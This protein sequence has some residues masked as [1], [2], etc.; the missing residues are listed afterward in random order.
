MSKRAMRATWRISSASRR[1]GPAVISRVSA[2]SSCRVRDRAERLLQVAD[3]RR[4]EQA[5][6]ADD[7]VRDVLVA[8]PRHDR[9]AMLVLAVQHGDV[10]PALRRAVLVADGVDDRDRLVLRAGAGH[11]LHGRAAASVATSRL[12]GSKRVWL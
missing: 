2:T 12:S 8:Q 1:H 5:Q 10:R 11:H 9:V 7:G 6:P 4:G 3:L